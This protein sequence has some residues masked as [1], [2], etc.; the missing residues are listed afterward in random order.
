[1]PLISINPG[2][3]PDPRATLANAEIVAA[4]ICRDLGLPETTPVRMLGEGADGW[5][6]FNFILGKRSVEVDIPGDDPETICKG[7]PWVSRRLYVDGAS[8]L[9]GYALNAI[10][11]HLGL[12]KEE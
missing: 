4:A 5:F 3:E 12:E 7:Q 6:R 8:W 10:S 2:T 1:M 9:Y 11:R